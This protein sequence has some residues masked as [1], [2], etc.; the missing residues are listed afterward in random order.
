[1][2]LQ[3]SF[4]PTEIM[5]IYLKLCYY[6]PLQN[7]R[8]DPR[9][10]DRCGSFNEVIYDANYGFL[11]EMRTE[12]VKVI[13]YMIQLSVLAIN[14]CVHFPVISIPVMNVHS[15]YFSDISIKLQIMKKDVQKAKKEGDGEKVA[16]L[17]EEI[18][19][20]ENRQK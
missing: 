1:M 9:F 5:L 6:S 4:D 15:M 16:L 13:Y 12:E 18:I 11:D 19:R 8:L 3:L 14:R 2:L 17:R 20:E 7:N 10:D